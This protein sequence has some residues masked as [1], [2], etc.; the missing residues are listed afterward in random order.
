MYFY[1]TYLNN[2]KYPSISSV[3]VLTKWVNSNP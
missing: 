3:E 2:D 1:V